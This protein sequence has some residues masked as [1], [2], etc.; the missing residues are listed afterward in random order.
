MLE[1]TP[2]SK[3][4]LG[5]VQ[6]GIPYGISNTTGQV[7]S[8]EVNKILNIA[9]A[10]CIHTL[11]TAIAYGSSETVLGEHNLEGFD[12][13]TKLPFI[14]EDVSDIAGWVEDQITGSL[15]RLK[16]SKV[17]AVLLHR[18]EQLHSETGAKI[19]TALT[20]L[21]H[22]GLT[23]RIGISIYSPNEFLDLSKE[24]YFDLI[25]APFNVLD[26]RLQDSGVF[27]VLKSQGT[28]LHVRSI[29]LQG[30]LLMD[31]EQRPNKFNHWSQLWTKW[32]EWLLGNKL[33]PLEACIRHA[34]SMPQ[35][36]KV[37]VGVDSANQLQEI[38]TAADGNLPTIPSDI[39]CADEKLLSPHLWNQL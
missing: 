12:I 37:V 26:T 7:S 9:K 10:E 36:E 18:P 11:D 8:S 22:R 1:K 31:K 16:T 4:A 20:S 29:F 32:D 23:E 38:V 2:I 14:P 13:I 39:F 30:L 24:F 3:V 28:Y 21:K 19:Y 33:T 6:F 5:T 17:N 34:L 25:Q 15:N 27:D 35:I